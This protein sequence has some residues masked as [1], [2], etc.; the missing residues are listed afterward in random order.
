L[1]GFAEYKGAGVNGP[2]N[3]DI[4]PAHYVF[5]V[6]LI[7]ILFFFAIR[8]RRNVARQSR[9]AGSAQKGERRFV[10]NPK[11]TQ[12]HHKTHNPTFFINIRV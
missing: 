8:R 5:L 6:A 3:Y 7:L 9:L 4:N 1:D 10:R 11:T 12:N 2:P